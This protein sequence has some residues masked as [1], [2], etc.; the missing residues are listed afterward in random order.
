MLEKHPCGCIIDAEK[1]TAPP[2]K[3]CARHQAEA[4]ETMKT[5]VA[6]HGAGCPDLLPE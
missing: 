4:E 6:E 1:F 3:L 2:V 5:L